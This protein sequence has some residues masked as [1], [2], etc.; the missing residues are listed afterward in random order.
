MD[1]MATNNFNQDPSSPSQKD[2]PVTST[3]EKMSQNHPLVKFMA[4]FKEHQDYETGSKAF[5][6]VRSNSKEIQRM[7]TA[8]KIH[9]DNGVW[10]IKNRNAYIKAVDLSINKHGEKLKDALENPLLATY[11]RIQKNDHPHFMLYFSLW[12]SKHLK[13]L[14]DCKNNFRNS[15]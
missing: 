10:R 4:A 9:L 2:A 11:L 15:F 13:H 8:I 12:K 1:K 3:P 6:S 7:N 14:T 5:E